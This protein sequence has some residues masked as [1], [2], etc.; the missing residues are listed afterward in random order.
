MTTCLR[1]TL[2]CLTLLLVTSVVNAAEQGEL[3]F[4]GPQVGEE[5][6]A[7]DAQ[8][9]FDESKTVPVLDGTADGPLLLIFVHQVT[10][11]SIGL[12]RLLMEYA[13]TKEKEGVKSRLVFLTD[14]PTDTK[15]L[16]QRARR[17]LPQGVHPCISTDG[18]EGPGAYGLNRKM[19]LTVL[20][21]SKGRVTANFPLVQPSIQADA[22]KIGHE[23][24]KVLG[25][26][27]APSLKEMGFDEQRRGMVRPNMAPEQTVAEHDVLY[28]QYMAPVIQKSATPEE[29]EAA[30][31]AVEDFAATTPW[32]KQRVYKASQL[33]SSSPRLAD[34]GT[35]DAQEY[36]Q[37][38]AKEFAPPDQPAGLER[39]RAPVDDS[40]GE[41]T[42]ESSDSS[43]D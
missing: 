40:T 5:L 24:L 20:V 3:L 41:T 38:W 15:A 17:A 18:I 28:R 7:F 6:A 11:P 14:D 9:A 4:S 8:R 12:T 31:K 33:I 1:E 10:R 34:Y 16:L 29:V 43:N 36:I 37:K 27:E 42:K 23:I 19:T 32:F 26:T 39:R 2:A 30:A 13:A 22:P 25:G 35:S 21:G